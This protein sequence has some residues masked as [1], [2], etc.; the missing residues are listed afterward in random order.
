MAVRTE[1]YTGADA[2]GNDG[3]TSRVLTLSNIGLTSNDDFS[4]YVSGLILTLTT[5]YTV[6]HL[7]AQ[8]QITFVN[9]LYN[10]QLI[11]VQYDEAASD[12]GTAS[13]CNA[14][15]VAEFLQSITFSTT[16]SPT[17][18]EVVGLITQHQDY[19][20]NKTGHA[21]RTT[22]ATNEYHHLKKMSYQH[23]DGVP[24]FL[25]NRKITTFSSGTDKLEIWD[26]SQWLDWVAN[27][28]EGRNGD[29]WV[30]YEQGIIFI[31]TVPAYLPRYFQVRVTYRYGD[32]TVPGDIKRACILRTAADLVNS[33]DRSSL[34]PE[35]TQNVP[36][37]EKVEKWMAEADKIIIDRKEIKVLSM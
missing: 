15:D 22:T 5:D 35:G 28:T 17:T 29:F 23:R 19:I 20:D 36:L 10:D 32:S 26:G 31:K 8:T 1:R 24:I 25:K 16:T 18:N 3:D 27:K 9:A 7:S 37:P 12:S 21:W 33:D 11:I 34:F 4:V 30:D 2:T 6:N 14:S 13:Y